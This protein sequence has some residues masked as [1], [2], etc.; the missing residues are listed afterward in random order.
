MPEWVPRELKA[1]AKTMLDD[2][3]SRHHKMHVAANIRVRFLNTFDGNP[4]YRAWVKAQG[5]KKTDIDSPDDIHKIPIMTKENFHQRYSLTDRSGRNG[6]DNWDM[7]AVS[8]GSTGEPT[9]WPRN[10]GHEMDV[11]YRF[12]QVFGDGF[13]AWRTPTLAVVCFALGAWVGGMYTASCCRLLASKG[14]PITTVTPGNNKTEIFRALRGLSDNFDQTVLLG[15]PPFLKDVVDTGIADGFDWKPLKMKLVMAGEV[16]SEEWRTLVC[17][18]VRSS[19]F[20]TASLY[21]TADAG[22]LGNETP[23]SIAIRRFLSQEPEA[24]QLLFGKARLPTLV[25]FDPLSRYI[26]A[27]DGQILITADS[28]VPIIRYNIMD[29]GGVIAYDDMLAF[30]K[31]IGFNPKKEIPDEYPIRNMPFVYVFGRANFAVSFFGANVYPENISVGLEQPEVAVF[32]T[33][34]FVMQVREDEDMNPHL[35][36]IVE[37][38]PGKQGSEQVVAA[39]VQAHLERLNSEFANYVPAE[40]RTPVIE[41]REAGDPEYFQPGIKHRYSKI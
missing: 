6:L 21:G 8:S 35:S 31:D 10:L 39:S 23:L 34:K 33:G 5:V 3:L 27:V 17:E 15:Y 13:A 30:L 1:F 38:A 37:L 24:A 7:V 25:Q 41:F 28:S 22:V 14:Y 29:R 19:V 40:Y 2:E 20:D 9:F 4:T 11:A 18:R 26:E 12:E 36:I 16:F 32:V